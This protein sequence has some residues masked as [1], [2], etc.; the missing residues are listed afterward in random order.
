M[1]VAYQ[2][3]G[4]TVRAMGIQLGDDDLSIMLAVLVR[5]GSQSP[6]RPL[7]P[8]P[9]TAEGREARAAMEARG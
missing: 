7:T 3:G 8:E 5:A 1:E 4:T 6:A 2:H 9:I